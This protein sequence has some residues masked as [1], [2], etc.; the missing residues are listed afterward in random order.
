[1]LDSPTPRFSC[2]GSFVGPEI[3]GITDGSRHR[4]DLCAAGTEPCISGSCGAN[5]TGPVRCPTRPGMHF[6]DYLHMSSGL[7][8]MFISSVE[9]LTNF[10]SL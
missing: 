2:T 1:M 6:H 7:T 8:D 5:L 4:G 3:P 10:L 9:T